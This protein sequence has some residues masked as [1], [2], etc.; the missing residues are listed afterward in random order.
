M[1][2]VTAV[3]RRGLNRW[4]SFTNTELPRMLKIMEDQVLKGQTPRMTD[5]TIIVVEP[6]GLLERV[7]CY[8]NADTS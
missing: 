4:S 3:V 2:H 8:E 1:R 5:L 7:K 6:L